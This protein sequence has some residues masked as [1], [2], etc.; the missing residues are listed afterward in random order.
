[1]V[2]RCPLKDCPNPRG[3]K[4]IPLNPNGL[5]RKFQSHLEQ[6]HRSINSEVMV[7]VYSHGKLRQQFQLRKPAQ[8]PQRKTQYPRQSQE[9][10]EEAI[11]STPTSQSPA[12]EMGPLAASPECENPAEESCDPGKSPRPPENLTGPHEPLQGVF[13]DDVDIDAKGF[14]PPKE[15]PRPSPAPDSSNKA[16]SNEPSSSAQICDDEALDQDDTGHQHGE[17][18]LRSTTDRTM[19]SA[20]LTISEALDSANNNASSTE[21]Q[22]DPQR[23]SE[24]LQG[25]LSNPPPPPLNAR[26]SDQDPR[27]PPPNN[28]SHLPSPL[29]STSK[30]SQEECVGSSPQVEHGTS[31][32]AP[33]LHPEQ[34]PLPATMVHASDD[35]AQP[36]NVDAM[37]MDNNNSLHEDNIGPSSSDDDES[38]PPDPH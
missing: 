14:A 13:E 15:R 28:P 31:V 4:G 33:S 2:Y 19:F 12:L 26:C 20:E 1:M 34:H 24:A 3:P 25:S 9:L 27:H 16:L 36:A 37:L 35:A 8:H 22:S 30:T 29:H 17:P 21:D 7:S 23:G 6:H 38:T 5:Q 18:S 10:P 11:C 32:G